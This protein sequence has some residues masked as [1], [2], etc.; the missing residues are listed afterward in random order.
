VLGVSFPP[1]PVSAVFQDRHEVRHTGAFVRLWEGKG[2]RRAIS[3][4]GIH[5]FGGV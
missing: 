3:G 1:S 2:C 4:R 5:I